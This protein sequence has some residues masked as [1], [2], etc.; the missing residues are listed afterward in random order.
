M[1]KRKVKNY[2]PHP[3]IEFNERISEEQEYMNCLS[4]VVGRACDKWLEEKGLKNGF[5]H[6]FTFGNAIQK[7]K[8]KSIT[9]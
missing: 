7:P 9:K 6:D 1:K 3:G 5:K 8:Q 4:R 2:L